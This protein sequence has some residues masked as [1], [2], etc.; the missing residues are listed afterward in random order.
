MSSPL[1]PQE[2]SQDLYAFSLSLK[3]K[4]R[5]THGLILTLFT[6]ALGGGLMINSIKAKHGMIVYSD[7]LEEWITTQEVSLRISSFDLFLHNALDIKRAELTLTGPLGER[8]IHKTFSRALQDLWQITLRVPDEP[9]EYQLSIT[10]EGFTN[11]VNPTHTPPHPITLRAERKVSVIR[12]ETTSVHPLELA[13]T[14]VTARA[15]QGPGALWFFAADQRLTMELSSSAFVVAQDNTHQPWQGEV[16]LK[17]TE[18]LSAQAVPTA[19]KTD[20]RG[21]AEV[22]LTTRSRRVS[23][24]ATATISS[25]LSPVDDT[26]SEEYLYPQ[27]YQFSLIT[28]QHFV[29]SGEMVSATLL[30]AQQSP[31]LYFDLWWGSRW[32]NTDTLT[33]QKVS[34]H[35]KVGGLQYRGTYQWTIPTLPEIARQQPQLLWVQAYQHPYQIDEV[36]GGRYLLWAPAEYPTSKVAEWLRAQ[37]IKLKAEPSEYW[38]R[39]SD[40]SLLS[41]KML[42]LALGRFARPSANTKALIDTAKSAEQTA[43]LRRASS[44][45]LYLRVIFSI[46]VVTILWLGLLIMRQYRSQVSKAEWSDPES[47]AYLRKTMLRWLA[48]VLIFTC[49]FFGLMMLLPY[50]V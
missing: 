39:I 8:H 7:G 31:K 12:G 1:S 38:S 20:A 32:I 19:V 48:Y 29:R 47:V 5:L 13:S 16:E 21:V 33:M 22:E 24:V 34:A 28:D 14:P 42:R 26:S 35:E 36:R 15:R 3:K 40:E 44:V 45:S 41:P 10:A 17:L 23:L 46:A 50:L 4:F 11:A 49:T 30:S 43:S 18:G 6:L 9:G 25:D 27:P 37:L 2:D